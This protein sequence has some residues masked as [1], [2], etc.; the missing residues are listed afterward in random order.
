MPY[1][2]A[3]VEEIVRAVHVTGTS[4]ARVKRVCNLFLLRAL[5]DHSITESPQEVRTERS[6]GM[7]V[8]GTLMSER[9]R[10]LRG[11]CDQQNLKSCRARTGICPL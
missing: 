1:L 9:L 11:C 3:N 10:N 8:S 6:R 2:R 7:C 4:H 5:V